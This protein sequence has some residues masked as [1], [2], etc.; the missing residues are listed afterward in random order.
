MTDIA[1]VEYELAVVVLCANFLLCVVIV[2]TLL[3]VYRFAKDLESAYPQLWRPLMVF[4]FVT[5]VSNVAGLAADPALYL[6]CKVLVLVSLIWLCVEVI[7]ARYRLILSCQ[8]LR[9]VSEIEGEIDKEETSQR[10]DK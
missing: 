3:S 9:K 8:I 5:G 2:L 4:V 10:A 7:R 1:T 6:A